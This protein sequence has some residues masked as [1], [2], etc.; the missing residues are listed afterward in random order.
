MLTVFTYFTTVTFYQIA[1]IATFEDEISKIF[2]IRIQRFSF[3]KMH[4]KI[5]SAKWWPFCFGI[6][7]LMMLL[8]PRIWLIQYLPVNMGTVMVFTWSV[9][10]QLYFINEQILPFR[11][12]K[13]L[14]ILYNAPT[15]DVVETPRL[16]MCF[17]FISLHL[18]VNSLRPGDAYMC[19][20][21]AGSSMMRLMAWTKLIHRNFDNQNRLRCN[22]NTKV[23]IYETAF[24]NEVCQVTAILLI[25]QCVNS[26]PPG[27]FQFNFR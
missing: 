2:W 17:C 11:K 25:S 7:V 23:S 16:H 9:S 24:E 3:A 1:N 4:L 19:P 12:P 18:K 8:F 15:T 13:Y 22:L 6:N 10:Q 21:W 14:S 26:L 5:S 27:R 20:Q